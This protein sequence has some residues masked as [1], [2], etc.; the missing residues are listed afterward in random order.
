MPN[1]S[2]M[3][4]RTVTNQMVEHMKLNDLFEPLQ[5]AYKEGHSI[6]TALLKVQND[7]LVA[8]DNQRVAILVLFDLSATF[9][10]VNHR[11]LLK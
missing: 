7:I 3:I 6:E 10:T 5:S 1:A 11:L 9:D 2:K 4:E 8:M